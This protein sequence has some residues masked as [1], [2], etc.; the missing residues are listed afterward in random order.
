M[1]GWE[2]NLTAPYMVPNKHL[3][4]RVDMD[5][6]LNMICTDLRKQCVIYK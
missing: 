2:N 4:R 1:A 5:A 3:V 6:S